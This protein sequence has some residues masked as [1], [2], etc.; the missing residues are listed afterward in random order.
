MIPFTRII[1]DSHPDV[2]ILFIE[3]LDHPR[4][5]FD[6]FMRDAVARHNAMMRRRYDDL[7]AGGIKGLHF[8]PSA[9]L[10]GDDNEH[11]VDALHMTDLGSTR[12]ADSLEPVIR[13]LLSLSKP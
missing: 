4:C 2:P 10:L 3:C 9:G 12:F 6:T 11:T 1:R 7:V 13:R 5:R 8:L